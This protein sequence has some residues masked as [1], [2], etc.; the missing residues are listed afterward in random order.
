MSRA[1]KLC[2]SLL[3][4]TLLIGCGQAPDPYDPSEANTNGAK[5]LNSAATQG[6]GQ[7]QN[8]SAATGRTPQSN[9]SAAGTKKDVKAPASNVQAPPAANPPAA[10]NPAATAPNAALVQQATTVFNAKCTTCHGALAQRANDPRIYKKTASQI[11]AAKT[12]KPLPHEAVVW[13][14]ATEISALEEAFK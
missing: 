4:M 13:P 5:N 6:Q 14:S 7:T 9:A 8:Q 12:T 10:N 2:S 11:T 1:H 3:W